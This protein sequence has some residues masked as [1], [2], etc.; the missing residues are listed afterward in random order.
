[1]RES[2]DHSPLS[3]HQPHTHFHPS[4]PAMSVR[5]S[6]YRH[7]FGEAHKP[8][9][10]YTDIRPEFT[11]IG[12]HI[13]ANDKYFCYAGTGGGGPVYVIPLANPGRQKMNLPR[14]AVH[15][16]K[17]LDFDWSPFIS[18]VLATC[19]EDAQIKV[20][21]I[22]EGGLE[23]DIQEAAASL[24]GHYKKV[25]A[26]TWHPT[27]NNI[28]SSASYDN[29]VKVWDVTKQSEAFSFDSFGDTPYSIAW[30]SN[31]SLIGATS[32]DKKVRA[33]D[34]RQADAALVGEG[35]SGSKQSNLVWADNHGCLITVGFNRGSMRQYAVYD[36]KKFDK[37]VMMK[38]IDQSGGV[39][40]PFYDPDNSV[41]YLA[42]KGNSNVSF[43]EVTDPDKVYY[44]SDFRSNEGQKG[45]CFASKKIVNVDECEVARGLRL[46]QNSVVPISFKVPRRGAGA[47]F[48]ADI[49]PDTYAGVPSLSAEEW[50][51]GQNKDPVLM[52]M[53]PKKR[54]DLPKEEVKLEV[55]KSYAEL[56]KELEEVKAKLA[57]AEAKLAAQ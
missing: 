19:G 42:G 36:P 30:N 4:S 53:D 5:K 23:T 1:M 37:P 51:A 22:P 24:E 18:E 35:F 32:K 52:S 2:L 7:N 55:K 9:L 40:M 56:E 11:G 16:A 39:I 43:F 54:E 49:Y 34:P 8:D 20:V 3:F 26:V 31:G 44:L 41:L 15:K 10:C 12:N 33:F 21:Q 14:V 46:L 50:L 25:S 38:D 17:V 13:A 29:T 28:I 48:Q 57:A 47:V 45:F 6:H 27:A